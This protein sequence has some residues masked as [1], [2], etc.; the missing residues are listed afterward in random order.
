MPWV[1]FESFSRTPV[2]TE[3]GNHSSRTGARV[4]KHE[5]VRTFCQKQPHAVVMGSSSRSQKVF[6]A[7]C[8]V[9]FSDSVSEVIDE[10]F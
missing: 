9:L 10:M 1:T 3:Q 5:L 4:K 6:C 2:R 8:A 7:A